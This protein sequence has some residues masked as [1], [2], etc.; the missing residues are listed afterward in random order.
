MSMNV[1]K[2]EEKYTITFQ[3]KALLAQAFTHSSYVNEHHK[4]RIEDNERLEFLGD[5]VLELLVSH[6][7]Y[8]RFKT[9]SEGELTKY[10][11]NIV[12]EP[13]LYHF[14]TK[15][16]L[17]EFVMLGKGE[18]R[19]GGRMRQALLADVFE[20]FLG[21]IYLDKGIEESRK[22]LE[23][24][25][26][27]LITDDVLL[28]RMD[29]KT[30]LQELIQERTKATLTYRIIREFGPSH[31][32]QFV[33]EVS[34]SDTKRATGQGKTKKEAEQKAAQQLYLQLTR[35]NRDKGITKD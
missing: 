28:H 20:A 1:S 27:P 26:F 16:G 18:E 29:Y 30:A 7:L 14:A 12:C 35:N 33:A 2:L 17:D 9:L 23:T 15:L 31:A 21:A 19:T 10:R 24:W 3:N 32:K 25:V 13:A 22:F 8:D 6:Y 34:I 11:A 4:G 5:A